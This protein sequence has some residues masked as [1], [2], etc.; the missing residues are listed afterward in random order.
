MVI[1]MILNALKNFNQ[2]KKN[3]KQQASSV[4]PNNIFVKS[5]IAH[6]QEKKEKDGLIYKANLDVLLK[7][8]EELEE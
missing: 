3:K 1:I 4:S 6:R 7:I 8:A 2:K 5:S